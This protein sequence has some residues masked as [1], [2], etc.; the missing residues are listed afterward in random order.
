LSEGDNRRFSYNEPHT[1]L[2][3]Y[4]VPDQR[5]LQQFVPTD[6]ELWSSARFEEFV[7]KRCVLVAD[8]MNAYVKRLT[9]TGGTQ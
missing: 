6:R 1:Y 9:G 7:Q 3:K 2:A 5:V 4:E 8:A